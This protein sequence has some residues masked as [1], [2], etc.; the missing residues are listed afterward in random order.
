VGLLK[1]LK[2][3]TNQKGGKIGALLNLI[4]SD[5]FHQDRLHEVI[6]PPRPSLHQEIHFLGEGFF[7]HGYQINANI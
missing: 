1:K 2:T 4:A 6:S 3:S 5:K 7:S